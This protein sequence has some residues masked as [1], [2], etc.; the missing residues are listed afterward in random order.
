MLFSFRYYSA[1]VM[2]TTELLA[3][4]CAQAKQPAW[5]H[6]LRQSVRLQLALTEAGLDAHALH[7]ALCLVEDELHHQ[8]LASYPESAGLP[9]AAA[10]AALVRQRYQAALL[11]LPTEREALRRE[12][13]VTEFATALRPTCRPPALGWRLAA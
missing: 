5:Q 9:E 4:Y 1:F 7:A 3:C 12:L 10:I 13:S 6:E 8:L 2:T 11:D